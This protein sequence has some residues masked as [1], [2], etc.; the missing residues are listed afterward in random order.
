MVKELNE[1]LK[2][3]HIDIKVH[4]GQEVYY[5]DRLL[6]DL[7]EE[8]IRYKWDKYLLIEFNMRDLEEAILGIIYELKIKISY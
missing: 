4:Y 6:E 3:E 2:N 7:E 8:V 5:S 1:I